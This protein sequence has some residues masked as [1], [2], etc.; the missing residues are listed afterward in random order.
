MKEGTTCLHKAIA[1]RQ[2]TFMSLLAI[3]KS[4]SSNNSL[5]EIPP[6]LI[7]ISTLPSSQIYYAISVH[8]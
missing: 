6:L 5:Y 3:L 8:Y 2:L 7:K 4:D 1:L